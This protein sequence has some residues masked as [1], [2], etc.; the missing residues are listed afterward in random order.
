[1]S[2]SRFLKTTFGGLAIA[3][4]ATA[5]AAAE[6]HVQPMEQFASSTVK[7]WPLVYPLYAQGRLDELR[8]LLEWQVNATREH[9]EWGMRDWQVSAYVDVAGY[10]ALVEAFQGRPERGIELIEQ[11]TE[12]ARQALFDEAGNDVVVDAAA[13]AGNFQ[14]MV[15]IADATGI[16]VDDRMQAGMIQMTEQMKDVPPNWSIYFLVEDIDAAASK[17]RELGGNILVPPTPTGDIGKFLV[18]QDPQGAVFS[19]IEYAGPASPPPG[20]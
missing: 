13:V 4:L 11:A 16:P 17:A 15:R 10:L 2:Y 7:N 12:A 1:M 3:A 6:P 14:R 9:P 18:A 8:P 19:I 20:Y 5:V